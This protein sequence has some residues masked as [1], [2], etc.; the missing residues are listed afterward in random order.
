VFPPPNP[1]HTIIVDP[2]QT[3]ECPVRADG[4]FVAVDVAIH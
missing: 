2:F 3:A 4:T 1:P